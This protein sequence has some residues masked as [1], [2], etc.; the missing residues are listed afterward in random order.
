MENKL[1]RE[2]WK[3]EKFTP[4]KE[5]ERAILFDEN[6]PLFITAAPGSGKTRVLLW[7][8]VYLIVEKGI[9]P[10]KIFLSTFTEK[11]AHQLTEGL[12]DLLGLIGTMRGG[13]A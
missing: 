9:S 5:Q 10:D 1:I 2:L 7:R 6:K 13:I 11:A 12:K 8:T 3:Q 4:N